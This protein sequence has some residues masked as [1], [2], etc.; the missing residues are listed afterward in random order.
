ML[1]S[2]KVK[3]LM[4]PLKEYP[5]V[6]ENQNLKEAFIILRKNFEE[7]KGYRSILVV[8][9]KNQ[10]R[11][12]LSMI[13][14]IKAV[15]PRFLKLSKPAGY[16]GLIQDDSTL[17]ILWEDLFLEECQKVAQKPIK[18]IL[19]PIK[20]TVTP[21]DSLTKAAFLL[22][23]TDSRILPVIDDGKIIGVIRLVDIFKEITDIVLAE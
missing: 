10:L 8:D 13:D 12:V 19:M 22:V 7:G 9:D 5:S 15:E 23:S 11:G 17:S 4:V 6:K 14:L 18:E 3:D 1:R 21:N 2:K 20:A 16:Q